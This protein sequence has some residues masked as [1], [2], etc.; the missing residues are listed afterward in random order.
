M[1]DEHSCS[2]DIF[3][4]R[5]ACLRGVYLVKEIKFEYTR[6]KNAAYVR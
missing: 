5:G 1:R 3:Y 4:M 2:D 6:E